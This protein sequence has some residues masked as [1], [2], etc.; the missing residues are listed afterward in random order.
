M[1]TQETL[2]RLEKLKLNGMHK[3][4]QGVL[5]MPVQDHPSV[6]QVYGKNGGGRVSGKEQKTD[7]S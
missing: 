3:A 4:Y 6:H 1:N 5:A 7:R 2:D